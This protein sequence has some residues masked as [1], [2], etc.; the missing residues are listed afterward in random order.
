VEIVALD[1]NPAGAMQDSPAV[2]DDKVWEMR[3]L[4]EFNRFLTTFECET[5]Q[6]IRDIFRGVALMFSLERVQDVTHILGENF[7]VWHRL[8][9]LPAGVTVLG[10]NL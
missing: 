9:D 4:A 6:V 2:S 3:Q 10:R 7:V 1:H 5:L 8:L